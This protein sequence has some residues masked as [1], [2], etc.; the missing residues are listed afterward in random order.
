MPSRSSSRARSASNEVFDSMNATP[1]S[2]TAAA[3][4]DAASVISPAEDIHARYLCSGIEW[5]SGVLTVG[6]KDARGTCHR[7]AA[8]RAAQRAND[9]HHGRVDLD[10][11]DMVLGRRS[12]KPSD[13]IVLHV[14]REHRAGALAQPTPP[15]GSLTASI[16][17]LTSPLSISPAEEARL[18]HLGPAS[19]R[20]LGGGQYHQTSSQ[21]TTSQATEPH[22]GTQ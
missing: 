16:M 9:A 7:S 1:C 4:D 22:H 10:R 21:A 5:P 14:H 2:A 17:S 18:T 15:D 8:R 19:K 11:A 12:A 13:D 20:T 6:G 3:K